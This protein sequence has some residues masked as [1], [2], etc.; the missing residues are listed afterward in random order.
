MAF[1][2]SFRLMGCITLLIF[3]INLALA[4]AID[5]AFWGMGWTMGLAG[6]IAFIDFLIAYAISEDA[7]LS[8]RDFFWNS[9]WGI[10]CKKLAWAWGT[11]LVIYAIAYLGLTFLT[12]TDILGILNCNLFAA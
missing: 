5:V 2:L 1:T 8:P 9:E 4:V 7:A 6:A 3:I 12:G 10:F 11:A